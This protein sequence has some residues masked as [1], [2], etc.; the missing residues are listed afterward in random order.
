MISHYT[1]TK[2]TFLAGAQCL[3]RMWWE[4][5]EP[6]APETRLGLVSRF[7]MEEGAKVGV[8]ARLYVP[9]GR[10]IKRGGRSVNAILDE[11][12][13]ALADPS[14]PAIYECAVIAD[15]TLV[16]A[17]I[18]ERVDGG[19]VLIEVK[20]KTSVS[21]QKHIPDVA[22]QAHALRAAGVTIVRCEIMHLNRDCVYPDL[23]N[24]FARE[25]VT[26]LIEARMETLGREIRDQLIT[27]R[28]PI[29]PNVETGSHCKRPDPCPFMDRCWPVAPTDHISTLYRVSEKMLESFAESGWETIRDL[30]DDVK[31][32]AIAA[33]QRRALREGH[34]VVER[35]ALL[36]AMKTLTYPVA[37]IDFE[38]IQPAIPLWK[39]CRPY[40]QI[41][42]Q[43]SCHLVNADHSES[44]SQWLF[45][46]R[47]D[48]RPGMARAILDACGPAATVTAYGAQFERGCIERLA[49]ACPDEATLL[50]GIAD[51]L[52]DLQPIVRET[53]YDEKFGGSFSIKKVVP[54]LVPELQYDDLPIAE[55]EVASVQLARVIL[56][57][58]TIH[59]EEKEELRKWLLEYC[60]RDTAAM[61]ALSQRLTE[62]AS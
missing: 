59:P 47:G 43:L 53:I 2:K 34:T 17:D 23:S 21:E 35:E 41:P 15:N 56:G 62:L 3:K 13:A 58:P 26:D 22:I 33:R 5:Y 16:F 24:L 39:G 29:A 61:V 18:L 1:L 11:S 12:K 19:F 37:H 46:G 50:K 8:L 48:P 31:L 40:D 6:A 25:D 4:M 32:S 14:V 38:T 30:P 57:G 49:E 27:A 51:S 54:A 28:L 9:G 44:H 20:S 10:L 42:V 60:K 7:R 45:D 52:V 55:A 36:E